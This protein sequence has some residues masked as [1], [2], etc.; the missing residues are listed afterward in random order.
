MRRIIPLS[1]LA[2]GAVMACST[3]EQV[4]T[5]TAIPTAGVRFI[6]AVPDT[7][8]AYGLDFRFV[9]LV[10]SNSH[11]RV[12]FRNAI[13]STA[14]FVSTLTEYKGA[15]E[16][17]RHFVVFLDDTI[18]AVAQTKLKDSTHSLVA[19]HNYTM[20][21]QGNARSSGADRMRLTIMDET[22]ADPGTQVAL[23]VVNTTGNPIDVRV[24]PQGGTVPAAATWASVP[25]YTASAYVTMA[26]GNYM[27]N[28]RAAGAAGNLITADALALPGTAATVDLEAN[29]G[30]TVAGSAISA[31][32]FPPSVAG[33]KAPQTA[34]FANTAIS[35]NWDRR[36]PRTCSPLC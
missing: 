28:V 33:S 19:T 21:M 14:P 8:A 22:V 5:T 24:Y 13:S 6:N 10:E 1:V 34:A 27:Y 30:T 25:A 3:P 29:P 35:F 15:K 9:D 23:R 16:G 32:V 26:P 31:F 11:F 20:L 36:P 7:G 18:Q 12:T 17:A 4:I 2:A